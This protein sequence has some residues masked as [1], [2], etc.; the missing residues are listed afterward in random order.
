MNQNE[1]GHSEAYFGNYRD[2]WWNDDFLEL[3]A[4]RLN[5]EN[6]NKVLDV[7]FGHGHWS[8]KLIPYLGETVDLTGVDKEENYTVDTASFSHDHFSNLKRFKV[9]QS[10]VSTLPFNNNEFDLVTCQTLLIHVP[11]P[12]EAIKEMIRV[13]K[14]GGLLLCV[15]PN[16]SVQALIQTS[17]SRQDSLKSRLDHVKYAMIVEEGKKKLGR[18]D[19][20]F[21]DL[22]PGVMNRLGMKRIKVYQSDKAIPLYPPYTKRE[23][24]AAI[25]QWDEA[26]LQQ[27]EGLSDLTYF[28]ALGTKYLDFYKT[29]QYKYS[30]AN[31]RQSY[32]IQHGEYHSSGGA[33]LYLV[34]GLKPE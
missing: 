4:K 3:I 29:Y 23:Q 16:N 26:G 30:F 19:S 2:H 18:G 14:P 34:S 33:L 1:G 6:Y 17:L 13:L 11:K 31:S 21:G 8:K 9:V 5:L 22:L 10:D 28:E 12:D 32:A 27:Q 15:E 24:K 25:D 7:G 20:S